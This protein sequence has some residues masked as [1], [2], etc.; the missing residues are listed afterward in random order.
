MYAWEPGVGLLCEGG[1]EKSGFAVRS[2][3]CRLKVYYKDTLFFNVFSDPI[4][5][6]EE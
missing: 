3:L 2:N 6:E 4:N 5:S 1:V